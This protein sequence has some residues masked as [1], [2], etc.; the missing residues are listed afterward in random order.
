MQKGQ[1]MNDE[2]RNL[3]NLAVEKCGSQTKLANKIGI[4]PSIVSNW[5]KNKRKLTIIE[6]VILA[7]IANLEVKEWLIR[8]TINKYQE[9]EKAKEAV[10]VLK[11]ALVATGGVIAT[12]TVYA[13]PIR[14][15]RDFIQCILL[16]NLKSRIFKKTAIS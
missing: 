3:I 1:K 4:Q 6:V 2:Y 7:E 10:N 14:Y 9:D 15:I 16:L 11:K 13:T 5:L 8:A 12:N